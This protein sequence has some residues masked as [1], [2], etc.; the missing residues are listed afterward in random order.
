MKKNVTGEFFSVFL[1]ELSSLPMVVY[2]V[3]KMLEKEY[4]EFVCEIWVLEVDIYNIY[5]YRCISQIFR[6]K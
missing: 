5:V 1:A 4:F 2:D 3:L 6:F